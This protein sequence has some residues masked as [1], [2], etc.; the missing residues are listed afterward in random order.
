MRGANGPYLVTTQTPPVDA[1]WSV[2]VYDTERGGRLHPNTHDRYHINDTAAVRN[3]DGTVT[4]LFKQQCAAS[5][6]NCLDVPASRFDVTI[7]Y[8]LPREPIVTGEWKFPAVIRQRPT[9]P[10]VGRVRPVGS[11]DEA[12]YSATLIVQSGDSRAAP[13]NRAK[14]D[15]LKKN[16]LAV[17]R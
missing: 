15:A 4:F 5:D 2:T 3:A 13:Q 16:A 17:V 8:Y 11:L 10:S 1:F 9:A 12:D 14:Y 6:S 7:R